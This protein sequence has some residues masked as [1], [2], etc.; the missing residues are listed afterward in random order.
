MGRP[1]TDLSLKQSTM[2]SRTHFR[3]S[4]STNVLNLTMLAGIWS[5]VH[6]RAE[7][8]LFK[9]RGEFSLPI[10]STA[11]GSVSSGVAQLRDH[12]VLL[13]AGYY[14]EQHYCQARAGAAL[15]L[16]AEASDAGLE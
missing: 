13:L 15:S 8:Q 1:L 14:G 10:G 16:F 9:Y 4:G 6:Q 7:C 11:L 2:A 3:S 12:H 5:S